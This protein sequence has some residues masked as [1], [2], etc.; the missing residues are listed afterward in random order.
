MDKIIAVFGYFVPFIIRNIDK[1]GDL[2]GDILA[3]FMA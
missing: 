2:R 1:P 3:I